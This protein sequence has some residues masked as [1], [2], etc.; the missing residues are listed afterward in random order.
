MKILL[1]LNKTYR[2]APDTGYWYL[3][4]P[5]KEL[6]HEVLW[7]DTVNPE[8]K[9]FTKVLESFRPDL[10]WCCFTNHRPI[11]PYEPWEEI[12][13]ETKWGRTTTFNW[14]CDD[15]WRFNNFSSGAC[16]FF[17]VCSTPEPSY[18]AK[19]KEVGYD[20]ITLGTW[21]ANSKF[22]SPKEFS[23]RGINISFV[24][25]PNPV[26]A[27]FFGQIKAPIRNIFGIS[28]EE[29]FE[30][31]A[32]TK[33][34]LNLSIN[35]NDPEGKTQMKQRMFEIP[36]AGGLLLTEHH[37]AL[38]EFFEINKEIFT[39]KTPFEC[40][41]KIKFL[42]KNP[43]IIEKTAMAGHKRFLREHDSKIRLAKVLEQ[44]RKIQ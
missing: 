23:K 30:T 14:F 21:H 33:I 27:A 39:F 26:R 32:R 29:L 38:G 24:G 44:I 9:N 17:N 34:G 36:A 42:L 31:H 37:D 7:Y 16:H 3:Y 25:A 11:A 5:L 15:T 13:K 1:A 35:A 18:I 19:Y 28:Q 22:Y 20:N 40:S 8:E 43:N 12:K 10:I 6:G 41:E 4:L 2:G